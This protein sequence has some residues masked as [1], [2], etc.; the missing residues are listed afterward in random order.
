MGPIKLRSPRRT[1]AVALLAVALAVSG[2]FSAG[3]AVNYSALVESRILTEVSL[4][5]SVTPVYAAGNVSSLSL[6]VRLPVHN[7]GGKAMQLNTIV[8]QGWL[9][10]LP[11]EGGLAGDRVRDDGQVRGE[12]GTRMLFYPVFTLAGVS[13]EVVGAGETADVLVI[14]R[15]FA[16]NASEETFEAVEDILAAGEPLWAHY[17]QVTLYV[18]GVPRDYPGLNSGYLSEM[19]VTRRYLGY[20]IDSASAGLTGGF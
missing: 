13:G 14:Q 20:D 8:Y 11:A 6:E 2:I 7:P 1:A 3:T 16:R 12:N 17:C 9:R 18:Y 15:S 5:V 19:S 10:D 4:E